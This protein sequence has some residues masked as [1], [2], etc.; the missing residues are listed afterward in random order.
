MF[1]CATAALVAMNT[2]AAV[3]PAE[4]LLP[5]DTLVFISAPDCAKLRTTFAS[6]AQGQF[7]ADPLMKPF[8]DNFLKKFNSD[9]VAP[10]EKELGVKF[11][12]YQEL[13]QGEI[14]LAL[15]QN[16]WEGKDDDSLGFVLLLD[17]KDKKDKLKTT[18]A[19]LKKKWIDANKELKT[20]KIRDIEFTTL[21][22][23]DEE[24]GKTFEKIFPSKEDELPT[25]EKKTPKKIEITVGQSESL[26]IVGNTTKPIEKILARQAGGL[27]PALAD[28]PIYQANRAA[29]LNG[30]DAFAWVNL[31]PILDLMIK[32]S[33]NA[34]STNPLAPKP[35]KLIGALGLGG[36][37]SAVLSYRNSNEGGMI[38]FFVGIPE[39]ER[40]GI[41]KLLAAEAKDSA[42]PSFVPADV[43]KYSRWRLDLQKT[44]NGLESMLSEVMP[45]ATGAF[46]MVFDYAG[47]DQDPNFDLRKELIGNFGD[48]VVTFERAP[49][50]NTLAE[51]S[52]PPSLFLLSS[53]NPEKLAI[54][55]KIG[56][57]SLGGQQGPEFKEREFLGRK[58]YSAGAPGGLALAGS[59]PQKRLHFAGSGGY[60]A[61]SS[62]VAILEEYL[63]S[64]D[65]KPKPLSETPGLNEL[66]QKVGGMGT[67]LFGF[68]NQGEQVRAALE[69]VKKDPSLAELFATGPI[70]SKLTDASKFKEWC[71]VSLL[72]SYDAISKY[73]Y[74]TVYAGTFDAS[75]FNLKFFSPTPPQLKK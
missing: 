4:K 45:A 69:T 41:V 7:W 27:V 55:F 66:A 29:L 50:G 57:S 12:D 44:W 22:T 40:R 67:G 48:D 10:L 32:G 36:L 65:N 17:S 16:G 74:Y 42:P 13:A 70:G 54:A 14:A 39:G 1:W 49:K 64:N 35:D 71:D 38:H 28:H 47:K 24:I 31:K 63:R 8:K 58:I 56:V 25:D 6:S 19:D 18:L 51:L 62:D 59:T 20:T 73:F 3:L 23:T 53:P 26:L 5:D 21:I 9:V 11:A 30:A 75:G 68:E 2:W 33:A 15:T 52:S 34:E 46:K 61:V 72:P 43:V 60:L 37:K